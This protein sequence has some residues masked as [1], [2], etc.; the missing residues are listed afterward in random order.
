MIHLARQEPELQNRLLLGKYQEREVEEADVC[1]LWL[2]W[3]QRQKGEEGYL[4]H[5]SAC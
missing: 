3:S 1:I 4:E 2:H 5:R